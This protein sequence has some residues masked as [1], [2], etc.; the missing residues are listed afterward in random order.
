MHGSGDFERVEGEAEFVGVYPFTLAATSLTYPHRDLI[1]NLMQLPPIFDGVE[2]MLE[3]PLTLPLKKEQRQAVERLVRERALSVTVHLPL[4]L[5]LASTNP[6]FRDASL[7]TLDEAFQALEFLEPK[8]YVLHVA[9]F[10]PFERTPL[11][12]TFEVQMHRSRMEA[13]WES[14]G[15]VAEVMDPQRIAVENLQYD[16]GYLEEIVRTHGFS[17]CM[18]VGHLRQTGSDIFAFYDRWQSRIRVIHLH[19]LHN[20]M[21]H[22][23]VDQASAALPL[24][25]FCL[26]LHETRYRHTLVLEQFHPQYLRRSLDVLLPLL[27]TC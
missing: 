3:Y 12:Q 21:D 4:S 14:L 17:V 1:H 10:M 24:D 15:K 26:L 11:G 19:D 25:A 9:P 2:I 22:Q 5:Q 7:R 6:W 20:G 27:G 13:A 16:F 23:L 18:D 8:A